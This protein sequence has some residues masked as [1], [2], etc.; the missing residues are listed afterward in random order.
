MKKILLYTLLLSGIIAPVALHA[1]AEPDSLALAKDEFQDNFYEALKQKGI[2]N[3]DRAVRSLEKCLV[4]EPNNPVLYNELGKNY[5]GMKNYSEAEKAFLKATQLDPKNRWYWQGLYDVYYDTKNYNKSI[6]IVQ[7]LIEWKKDFYQED[8]VS[9]YMYTQQYDKALDLINEMEATVGMSEKREA[10][11]MQILSDS[12]YKKSKKEALEEAIKKNPKA[13]SNYIDLIYLYSESNQEAKAEQVAKQLEKEIPESDWAQVSMFKFHLNKNEGGQAAESMFR[14]LGSKKIDSKIKHRV[15]NEF[16]IFVNANPQYA[17]Q[18]E[19]A[20]GYFEDDK[21]VD[22]AKEVGKFF[23]NKKKYAEASKY[24]EKSLG[25]KADDIEAIELLLYAYAE[26]GRNDELLKKASRY[27]D[28]YPTH[29]RL[30]YFAGLG[31]NG[32]GQY[33][34]AKK[35]LEDGID[36]VVEDNAL[37]AGFKKELTNAKNGLAKTK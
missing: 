7:K 17:P 4:R 5:L 29:A 16:L 18:L 10:Y 2:E 34:K 37:E 25:N 20:V 26:G 31:A 36:F 8:L 33:A 6:P 22:V 15:L 23:F 13:E 35:W 1:Q 21:N 14:V 27:I 12:K 3:Y 24:F 32:L 19:K 11:K 9:L 30:Y 28:L